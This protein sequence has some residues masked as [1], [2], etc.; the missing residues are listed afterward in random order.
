MLIFSTKVVCVSLMPCVDVFKKQ[1]KYSPSF[2]FC[3]KMLRWLFKEMPPFPTP[4]I[5]LF[6]AVVF[7]RKVQCYVTCEF[8]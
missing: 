3:S 5:L 4:I 1:P 2:K 8:N 6:P 7:K